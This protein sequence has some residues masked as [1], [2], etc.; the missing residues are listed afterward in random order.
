MDAAIA[1][2]FSN[3]RGTP[4]PSWRG[5]SPS[6]AELG[7]TP[8][9]RL[10]WSDGTGAVQLACWHNEDDWGSGAWHEQ[11]GAVGFVAG[12]LRWRGEDWESPTR[13]ARHLVG[14]A[15]SR[16]L[17]DL[18]DQLRGLF[19]AS[20]LSAA[21]DGWLITDVMGMRL[22]YWGEDED[23]TV[24]SSRAALVAEGLARFRGEPPR[25]DISACWLAFTGFRVGDDTGYQGVHVAPPGAP[26]LV[27]K[28]T[29]TW[30]QTNPMVVDPHDELR[31][32]TVGELGEILYEDVAESLRA[33]LS[34]P[35]ERHIIRLTGGKDSRLVL[36]VALRAGLAREFTY[37]TIGPPDLADV[38]IASEL[39]H[40]F[41][42]EHEVRFLGLG[43]SEPFASR[44][45]RFV[46][47]TGCMVNGREFGRHPQSPDL[48]LTGLCGELLRRYKEVPEAN[49]T[50]D[51]L[52]DQFPRSQFGRLGLLRGDLADDLHA[53]FLDKLANEPSPAADPLDR[54]HML[55]AGSR[56][57][58]VRGGAR[59][60]L[61]GDPDV[62]PLYSRTAMR[63][64]M[65]LDGRDRHS[66]LLFAEVMRMASERLV[67]HRFTD[68]GWDTRAS[69]HLE[70]AAASDPSTGSPAGNGAPVP[71]L[72]PTNLIATLY[73][74]GAKD[75]I[76][77]LADVLADAPNRAWELLDRKA[78]LLALDR[79]ASLTNPQRHELFGAA[80]IAVWLG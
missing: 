67:R 46:E 48:R 27:H 3:R 4:A 6:A 75:R 39:C 80:S 24:V 30:A 77:F 76:E 40:H 25:D 57:R 13:W 72:K 22:L 43:T 28:A 56:M 15:P 42:L 33:A 66:E 49:W 58:F 63:A 14:A 44:F 29:P 2:A 51:R 36:A 52:A 38:Q 79:Y 21:G 11:D 68:A 19:I 5:C 20:Y 65:A 10:D 47:R 71:T 50:N 45:R 73:S 69:A 64:A 8:R 1:V 26:L 62:L 34:Y 55:Y 7:F 74:H 61:S 35:A 12:S 18:H 59:E 70:A 17:D 60:E 54:L 9:H 78:A 16:S 53:R 32:C 37:E 31:S 23:V 41:S